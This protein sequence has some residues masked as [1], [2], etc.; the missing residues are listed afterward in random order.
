MVY[1]EMRAAIERA[2][3]HRLPEVASAL[4]K[5]YGAGGL[6]DAEAENLSALLE[7]RQGVARAVST[8]PTIA[9]AV[10]V[11]PRWHRR[12]PGPARGHGRPRAWAAAAAGSR[13]ASCHRR[14]RLLHLR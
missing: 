6:T 4:W 11:S 3:R 13:P 14:S 1:G 8:T 7:A 2:E 12:A 5:A 10:A 9:A